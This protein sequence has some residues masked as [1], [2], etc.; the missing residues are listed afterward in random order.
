MSL[1]NVVIFYPSKLTYDLILS[2]NERAKNAMDYAH[3]ILHVHPFILDQYPRIV[4]S[5]GHVGAV[6]IEVGA[7]ISTI[8][9][10]IP[11]IDADTTQTDG[12]FIMTA[13][14]FNTEI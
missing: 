8:T 14:D 2:G 13:E 5:L 7:V 10:M 3:H 1:A 11:A 6:V 9:H 12:T 4:E